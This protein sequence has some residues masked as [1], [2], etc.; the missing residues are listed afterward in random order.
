M[1]TKTKPNKSNCLIRSTGGAGLCRLLL[2]AAL[3]AGSLSAS[4]AALDAASRATN[5]SPSPWKLAILYVYY[6]DSGN[7]IHG[8]CVI[9]VN[10]L[11]GERTII[12]RGG[13]LLMPFGVVVTSN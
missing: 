7:A 5:S 6:V 10:I 4:P 2:M 12:S 8:G 11:T 9:R 1:K 3:L 13:L